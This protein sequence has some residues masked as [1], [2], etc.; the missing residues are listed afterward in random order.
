[1]RDQKK[2]KAKFGTIKQL[3]RLQNVFCLIFSEGTLIN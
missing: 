2:L 3:K 1:M